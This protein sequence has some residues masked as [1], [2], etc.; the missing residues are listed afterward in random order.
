MKNNHQ[1]N[2]RG[3]Y[4]YHLIGTIQGKSLR[5]NPK[6]TQHFYQ[7]TIS[8]ENL[9]QITKITVFK[10]KVSPQIWKAIEASNCFGKRYHFICRN[11][12]GYY[13]LVDW[14]EL[15]NNSEKQGFAELNQ[16]DQNE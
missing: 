13:Y 4:A 14:K 10:P 16:N 7:L 9:S 12:S 5:R 3:N 6:Y 11:Y 15:L 1:N 2:H 8:C